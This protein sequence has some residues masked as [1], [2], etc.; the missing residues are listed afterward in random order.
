MGPVTSFL[1]PPLL[2]LVAC[3]VPE[4]CPDDTIPTP[5]EE[6]GLVFLNLSSSPIIAY[7]YAT[8]ECNDSSLITD[9][10]KDYKIQ[11][12]QDGTFE[13]SNLTQLVCR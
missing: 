13:T 8:Y 10:G 2:D 4:I 11:C 6:S 9:E 5:T 7:R 12:M 3:Q 1:H